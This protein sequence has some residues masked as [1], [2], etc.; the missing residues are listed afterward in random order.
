MDTLVDAVGSRAV[1]LV[2][3]NCEHLVGACAGLAEH[4]L[5][6]CARLRLL[7]TSREPLGVVGEAVWRVPSLALPDQGQPATAEKVAECGAIRL[8]VERARL[9]LTGF[10]LSDRNAP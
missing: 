3:D 2:V 10:E 5:R 4:L 7:A 1:L 9:V 6:A 8:F